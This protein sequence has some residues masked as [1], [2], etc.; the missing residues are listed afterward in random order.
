ML[1]GRVPL[2]HS[3]FHERAAEVP[4]AMGTAE[5]VAYCDGFSDPV[6]TMVDGWI[7]SPGHRR[8]LLGDFNSM[9]TAF[10]N[11]GGLWYGT[12]FFGNMPY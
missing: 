12:Q 8:N 6:H 1:S 5:N 11:R 10:A 2:G 4:Q 3:G 7:K 9:G